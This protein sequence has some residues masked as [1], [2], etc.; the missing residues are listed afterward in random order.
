[1]RMNT[2]TNMLSY[3]NVEKGII[4]FLI[5]VCIYTTFFATFLGSSFYG[6]G[7]ALLLIMFRLQRLRLTPLQ[8]FSLALLITY[9]VIVLMSAKSA[10]VV[11]KNVRFWYGFTIFLFF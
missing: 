10:E 7:F 3:H 11:L 9:V 1:M 4:G 6:Y 5:T 2:L 8:V